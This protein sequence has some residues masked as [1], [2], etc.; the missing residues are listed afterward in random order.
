MEPEDIEARRAR[1]ARRSTWTG[2]LIPLEELP[3][4]EFVPGT[5]AERV[6]MV[7]DLTLAAW[8]MRGQDLPDYTR[9][10]A[11]GRVVPDE[12]AA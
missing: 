10:D 3:E 9:S 2:G 11:P 8:A 7:R 1:A 6:G 5:P 4:T 12:T